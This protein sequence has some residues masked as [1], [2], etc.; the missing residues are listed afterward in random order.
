MASWGSVQGITELKHDGQEGIGS[1]SYP[2][3]QC[4]QAISAVKG[5]L[6]GNGREQGRQ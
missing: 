5:Q 4:L 6:A 2:L 3:S 1:S